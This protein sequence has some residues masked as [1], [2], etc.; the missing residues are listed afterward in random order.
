LLK[1]NKKDIWD[2]HRDELQKMGL[3]INWKLFIKALMLELVDIKNILKLIRQS[4]SR[5]EG[6]ENK[7]TNHKIIEEKKHSTVSTSESTM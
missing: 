7:E 4:I 5:T 1:Y 6:V 2:Y 3:A